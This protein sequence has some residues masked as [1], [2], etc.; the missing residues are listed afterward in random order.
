MRTTPAANISSD[1]NTYCYKNW[2]TVLVLENDKNQ[3]SF[4]VVKAPF[5]TILFPSSK[6]IKLF[7]GAPGAKSVEMVAE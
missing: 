5:V 4:Y 1:T 2:G 3:L 7:L 6:K